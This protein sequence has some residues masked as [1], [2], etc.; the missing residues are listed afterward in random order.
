MVRSASS[1]VSNHLAHCLTPSFETP[2]EARA[3]P[4]ATTAKPLRGDKGSYTA[5]S[6]ATPITISAMPESSRADSGCLNE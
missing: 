3:V 5:T 1:R 2:R 6:I 4:P